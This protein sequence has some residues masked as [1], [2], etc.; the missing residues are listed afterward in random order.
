MEDGLSFLFGAGTSAG[1]IPSM[2]KM[3][4]NIGSDLMRTVGLSEPAR[5][6]FASLSGDNLEKTLSVLYAKRYYLDGLSTPDA[7][8]RTHVDE[9]IQFIEKRMFASINI[10]LSSADAS[11]MLELYKSLYQK[12][13]LRNKD[14]SRINVFT[15]NNDCNYSAPL[16]LTLY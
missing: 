12:I 4:E 10:D 7:D 9:L 13:A 16:S 5:N 14:L 15:L 2:K 1:A 11:E 8:G 6:L 3:Q